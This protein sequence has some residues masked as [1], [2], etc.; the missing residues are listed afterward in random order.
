M[1]CFLEKETVEEVREIIMCRQNVCWIAFLFLRHAFMPKSVYQTCSRSWHVRIG[2]RVIWCACGNYILPTVLQVL[3]GKS[4]CPPYPFYR[5]CLVYSALSALEWEFRLTGGAGCSGPRLFF[6]FSRPC[7]WTVERMSLSPL[8]K[9]LVLTT[10]S[11]IYKLNIAS[12]R[13]VPALYVGQPPF[14]KQLLIYSL[15]RRKISTS[16]AILG[17]LCGTNAAG[18]FCCER[19]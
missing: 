2:D 14:Q 15:F 7:R 4:D 8:G 6:A 9:F 3:D 16:K 10:H 1:S 11:L 18:L 5:E 19:F 17:L 13:T 12:Q